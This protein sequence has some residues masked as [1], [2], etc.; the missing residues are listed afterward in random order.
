MCMVN[1]LCHV[2]VTY[3]EI[4][5]LE[6]YRLQATNELNLF[7]MPIH[8]QIL[9]KKIKELLKSVM[10]RRLQRP[11]IYKERLLKTS[12]VPNTPKLQK[13]CTQKIQNY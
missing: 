10:D 12:L 1:L 4:T 7:H 8:L 6:S 13:Y 5:I 3:T 2:T 9:H 11:I